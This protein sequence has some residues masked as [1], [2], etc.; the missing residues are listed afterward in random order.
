MVI[1][2]VSDHFISG[3]AV[4]IDGRVVAAVNDERLARRKVPILERLYYDLR[5]PSFARRHQKIAE[6]LRDEFDITCPVEFRSHHF[7]HAAGAYYAG[8]FEDGLMVTL[9]GAGDG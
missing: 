9:D 7:A 2:G 8:G 3:A 5:Q 4:V 1:L 6:V